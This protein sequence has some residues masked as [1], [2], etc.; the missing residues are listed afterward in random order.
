MPITRQAFC[1]QSQ[2]Q[3]MRANRRGFPRVFSLATRIALTKQAAEIAAK[4]REIEKSSGWLRCARPK[5]PVVAS[6]VTPT[7]TADDAATISAMSVLP[8]SSP[9]PL[10]PAD[11]SAEERAAS[12]PFV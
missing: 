2:K 7:A 10:S 8:N 11:I 9:S 1:D 6:P 3:T 5:V 4:A 12:A